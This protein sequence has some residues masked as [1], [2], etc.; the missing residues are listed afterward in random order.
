MTGRTL[1]AL[2]ALLVAL[3]PSAQE[4]RPAERLANAPGYFFYVLPLELSTQVSVIGTVRAPGFYT[5]SDGLNLGEVLALAGG[6]TMALQS[7]EVERTITIRLYRGTGDRDLVYEATLDEFARDAASYPRL[8]DGDLIEVTTV[9][10][11][12]RTY[13]DTLTVIGAAASVVIAIV[14]VVRLF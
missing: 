1:L 13:R 9:D 4:I 12:L 10:R 2:A 7:T 5:V 6:P 11:R 14:Q 3:A 8:I